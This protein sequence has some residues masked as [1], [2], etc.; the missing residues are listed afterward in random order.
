M[1]KEIAAFLQ[2]PYLD[3]QEMRSQTKAGQAAQSKPTL[4]DRLLVLARG[5]FKRPA[6][7]PSLEDKAED[8]AEE[9]AKEK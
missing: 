5:D 2:I 7:P 6:A 4:L 9:P 8:T 1:A 3:E